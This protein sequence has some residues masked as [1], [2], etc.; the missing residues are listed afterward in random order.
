MRSDNT[1]YWMIIHRNYPWRSWRPI[2]RVLF[3][4]N[5]LVWGAWL[6]T[7]HL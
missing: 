3:I 7:G 1:R 6:V 4:A 2:V 5:I